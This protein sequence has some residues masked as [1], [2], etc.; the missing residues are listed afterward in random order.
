M[1]RFSH[2]S[3]L[4]I[5]EIVVA[6]AEGSTDADVAERFSVDRT[7]VAY[8]RKKFEQAYPEQPSVY[9]RI[10]RDLRRCCEHPSLKC[11]LCGRHRDELRRDEKRIIRELREQL[12]AA[13]RKLMKAGIEVE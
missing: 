10:K 3:Q 13:H 8:H 1:A 7:T 12:E 4:Q 5:R 9:G 2:L 6:S 11:S